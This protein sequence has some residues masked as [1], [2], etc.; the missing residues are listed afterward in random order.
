[1]L[2]NL[3]KII[4]GK[5]TYPPLEQSSKV[6]QE[7]DIPSITIT[8]REDLIAQIYTDENGVSSAEQPHT[9]RTF[10]DDN[11]D[12]IIDY[13][14]DAEGKKSDYG[15]GSNLSDEGIGTTPADVAEDNR[16]RTDSNG[17]PS[18]EL[19]VPELTIDPNVYFGR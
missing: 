5:V 14:T 18:D 4:C 8:S 3:R 16:N 17:G 15:E 9:G 10:Y 1:L 2:V 19:P 12:G 7:S 11:R 6:K 13:S